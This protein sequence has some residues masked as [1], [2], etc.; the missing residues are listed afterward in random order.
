MSRIPVV[1]GSP[2]TVSASSADQKVIHG[3]VGT[4]A[5]SNVDGSGS[6]ASGQSVT[7][8]NNT[9]LT[10][11]SG[12]GYVT[13]LDVFG[14]PDTITEASLPDSVETTTRV[15][16]RTYESFGAVGDGTTDDSVAIQA[17]WT[18]S[19]ANGV[20]VV[21]RKG[22]SY[23]I[24]QQGTKTFVNPV[25][26]AL[27]GRAYGV[28]VPTGAIVDGQGSEFTCADGSNFVI[29]SNARTDGSGADIIDFQGHNVYCGGRAAHTRTLTP[30][31]FHGLGIGSVIKGVEAYD[32]DYQTISITACYG[33]EVDLVNAYRL[34]GNGVNIGGNTSW[35]CTAMKIGTIRGWDCDNLDGASLVGNPVTVGC[36][37]LSTMEVAWGRNCNAGIK[38][39]PNDATRV[40]TA[41]FSGEVLGTEDTLGS[42]NSGVKIQGES[43]SLSSTTIDQVIAEQCE[44]AGLYMWFAE[45]ARVGSYVGRNND[46]G[47]TD[48]DV[49]LRALTQ[50]EIGSIHSDTTGRLGIDFWSTDS[51]GSTVEIG[52]IF[53]R[54]C[55]TLVG[56]TNKDAIAI[57]GAWDIKVNGG[58]TTIDDRATELMRY[59]IAP[60]GNGANAVLRMGW[61]H[62]YGYTSG[63][64]NTSQATMIHCGPVLYGTDDNVPIAASGGL[65]V[66]SGWVRDDAQSVVLGTLPQRARIVGREIYVHEEFNSDGT[67]NV[68]IGY[69]GATAAFATNTDVS[70]TGEKT[71]TAGTVTLLTAQRV[72]TATYTNG[73]SEPTTGKAL[74]AI[75]YHISPAIPA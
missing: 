18:Y 56:D 32:C 30:V 51:D 28:Q 59:G 75:W 71:V 45:K 12:K 63:A 19:A 46:T 8:A 31:W 16:I 69:T 52:S 62:A 11:S 35:A 68:S 20:K 44:G 13:V 4:V 9:T 3:Q 36:D 29:V 39:L 64:I 50:C 23:L 41:I 54:N 61:H 10:V 47:A 5:Y 7:V 70:T 49:S 17:A 1:A 22:A 55:G 15:N 6:L 43:G 40:T 2:Q 21:G 26:S 33:T 24:T 37:K 67:D 53:V 38:F 73:G 60:S 14:V 27:T 74:V 42:N 48:A 57:R 65:S 25:G 58:V 34:D 72:C 66:L